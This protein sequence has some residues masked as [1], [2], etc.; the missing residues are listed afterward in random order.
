MEV[1]TKYKSPLVLLKMEIV[2][3]TFRKKDKSLEG[4][5]LGLKVNHSINQ[6]GDNDFELTLVITVSDEEETV[7]VN[8]KGKALFHTEQENKVMLERN[9]IAIMFPYIRS[10]ISTITTQPGMSPIVLPAMNIVA[11]LNDQK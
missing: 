10:Y 7:F 4:I 1:N 11:M 9:G 6:V 2:E 5:E 8:V 3:G